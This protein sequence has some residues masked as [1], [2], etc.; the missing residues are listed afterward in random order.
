MNTYQTA[1]GAYI[2]QIP[3]HEF[4]GLIGNSYLV[5]TG[6]YRVLIDTGSGYG[7]SNHDLEKGLEE[8]SIFRSEDCSFRSLTHIFITHGHIDHYGGL[9]FIK[10]KTQAQVC[11]HE[12]DQ[13]IVANHDERVTLASHRLNQFLVEAGVSAENRNKQLEMYKITK[14]LFQSVKVDI[15]Y[16]SAGM[17]IGPFIFTHVPGHCAGHVLIR[18]HDVLFSG[19]QI[20]EKTSPHQVPEQITPSTGL[21]TYLRSLEI[22]KSIAKEVKFTLGGHEN[23]IYDLESRILEIKNVHRDRLQLILEA[24]SEPRTIAD[25]SKLLFGKVEGYTILLALEEAGAHIEYLYQRGYLEI[26][27]ISEVE[28]NLDSTAFNYKSIVPKAINSGQPL[29]KEDFHVFI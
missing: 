10:N 2:Y 9:S 16:E 21:E 22:V 8:I 28:I 14:S 5:I 11:I 4:P 17:Y 18:L 24:L 23:P 29:T 1:G 25:I 20:L 26:S 6:V 15:T 27:N 13:R 7:E 19:D 12:L 3:L